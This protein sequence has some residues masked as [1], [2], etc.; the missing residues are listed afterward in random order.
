MQRLNSHKQRLTPRICFAQCLLA[1]TLVSFSHLALADGRG[2]RRDNRG[3]YAER[4]HDRGGWAQ[5][6]HRSWRHSG[7]NSRWNNRNQ[8]WGRDTHFNGGSFAGGLVIGSWLGS[9]YSHS[10]QRR[11][12][13]GHDRRYLLPHASYGFV[14]RQG[15]YGA[16]RTAH[17]STV[18]Y[19]SVVEPTPIITSIP[20]AEGATRRLLLDLAGDCYDVSSDGLGNEIRTQ[21]ETAA[22][23]F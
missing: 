1:L 17:R 14:G 2:D 4:Q 18:I 19:T 23:T 15:Y 3:G 8:R 10:A 13:R 20:R 16:V 11:S 7:R 5:N 9:G 21:L 6:R 12:S 22:C